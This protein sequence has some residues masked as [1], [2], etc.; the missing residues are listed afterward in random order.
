MKNDKNIRRGTG[1]SLV[2]K[3]RPPSCVPER[4]VSRSLRPCWSQRQPSGRMAGTPGPVEAR[5]EVQ[6]SRRVS[7][8]LEL[9]IAEGDERPRGEV[10]R[11]GGNSC[12][13]G[14]E[15]RPSERQ[16]KQ[17]LRLERAPA[18]KLV[19]G[20]PKTGSFVNLELVIELQAHRAR[21]GVDEAV[22]LLIIKHVGDIQLHGGRMIAKPEIIL[23]EQV[24]VVP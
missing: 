10:E 1:P 12:R 5:S 22:A 4:M 14:K 17:T 6:S 13:P 21:V 7:R 23:D 24:E 19:R 2:D 18:W 9:S 3:N 8:S 11:T 20:G 16:A 15:R